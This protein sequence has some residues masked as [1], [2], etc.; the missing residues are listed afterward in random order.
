[1]YPRG[2]N[3]YYSNSWKWPAT[4]ENTRNK[5]LYEVGF[6]PAPEAVKTMK[7]GEAIYS[8]A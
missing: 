6:V 4:T 2:G 1:M 7:L 8:G 5:Y 3:P